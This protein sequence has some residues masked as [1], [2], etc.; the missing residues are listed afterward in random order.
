MVNS[1][2][3]HSW[4][5]VL[6]YFI[7]GT[8]ASTNFGTCKSPRTN[9]RHIPKDNCVLEILFPEDN[10]VLFKNLIFLTFLVMLFL[11]L[12]AVE[13]NFNFRV[14]W[15]RD[16]PGSTVVSFPS[17]HYKVC[18]FSL[19]VRE[20]RLSQAKW[21]GTAKKLKKILKVHGLEILLME[22]CWRWRCLCKNYLDL[23]KTVL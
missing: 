1:L 11:C 22:F 23:L 19:L 3:I 16:Y 15:L 7:Y 8:W 4:P 5:L 18:W 12:P 9:A 21:H 20:L 2:E 6:K 14:P 17:F 13:D 10:Q